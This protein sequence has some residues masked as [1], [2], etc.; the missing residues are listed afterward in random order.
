MIV[1]PSWSQIMI[2][3]ILPYCLAWFY[4]HSFWLF[5]WLPMAFCA[6]CSKP[7]TRVCPTSVFK[8]C[9]NPIVDAASGRDLIPAMVYG[10][11][12]RGQEFGE[13]YCA[14]LVVNSSVVSAAMLRIFGSDV[15]ELPLVATSNRNHGK[16]YFQTLFSCNE[17]LLAF[18][19][20]KSLVLPA[21]EEAESIWTD[22]F[23]FSRMK[24]DEP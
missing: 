7:A 2:L 13:M 19:N 8:E 12:V 14:L 3:C 4:L 9:F 6:L 5:L 18:M 1:W 15:A 16:G 23:G 22:K 21:A 24:P 17:R 10:R 20:V 11:N